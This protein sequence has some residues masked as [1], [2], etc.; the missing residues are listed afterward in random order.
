MLVLT[1]KKGESI[2]VGDDIEISILELTGDTVRIG[3]KAP[4]EVGILRKELYVSVESMNQNAE[5]SSI[6]ASELINQFKK[7]KKE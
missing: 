5:K 6:T 2:L 3:I 4:G 7:M 1:R